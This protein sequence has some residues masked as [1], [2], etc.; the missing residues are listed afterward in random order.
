MERA[1]KLAPRLHASIFGFSALSSDVY[2]PSCRTAPSSSA[3][4]PRIGADESGSYSGA[5]SAKNKSRAS[6]CI[7]ASA[8]SCTPIL[9]GAAM[10]RTD[11]AEYAE[12]GPFT[13]AVIMMRTF[14]A[15]TLG[16]RT[17]DC[18]SVLP[19]TSAKVDH[20]PPSSAVCTTKSAAGSFLRK[21]HFLLDCRPQ[22][23]NSPHP[24]DKPPSTPAATNR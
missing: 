17:I 22:L 11:L 5:G 24:R 4:V 7:D 1:K 23:H 8:Q 19:L 6:P 20:W 3:A 21:T 15:T 12:L 2:S 9:S 13:G 14:R 18:C 16:P 10:I